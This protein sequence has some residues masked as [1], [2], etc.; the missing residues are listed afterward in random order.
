MR[1][2]SFSRFAFLAANVVLFSTGFGA[3][4]W[5]ATSLH[6]K[7]ALSS[8]LHDTT[9]TEQV[10]VVVFGDAEHAALWRGTAAS[11]VDL[12]PPL[13]TRSYALGASDGQQVGRAFI[14]EKSHAMAW[15]GTAAS[16][17]DLHPAAPE[18]QASQLN[19]AAGTQQCGWVFNGRARATVWSGS[20]PTAVDLHP[21][22]AT[23]S[24]AWATNGSL[25]VGDATLNGVVSA[26]RWTGT[27]ESF[28]LLA[29]DGALLSRVHGIERSLQSDAQMVGEVQFPGVSPHAAL[30]KGSKE[31]F[32]DLH[33]AGATRSTAQDTDGHRQVGSVRMGNST[34]AALWHGSAETFIDLHQFLPAHYRNSEAR[35]I[36][37]DGLRTS[38]VGHA[39]STVTDTNEAIFWE[40][41]T[42]VRRMPVVAVSVHGK[43]SRKT[44]AGRGVIRGAAT[45]VA[46]MEV[47][48]HGRRSTVATVAGT[49]EHR[50]K[51]RPGRNRIFVLAFDAEGKSAPPIRLTIVRI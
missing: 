15:S 33:P 42:E 39:F 16:A 26:G 35:A 51:L 22:G 20:A 40:Q 23:V 43:L 31:S 50:L 36:W 2:Q 47:L 8:M 1:H 10:G 32:L 13:A 28:L 21:A 12:H 27:S 4:M 46:R 49:W 18:N 3:P 9:G 14:N 25:Q 34:R 7:G 11:F 17:R 19:G 24:A 29:P 30:W 5:I 45:N 48:T 38:V 6:P 37:S 41:S 44:A